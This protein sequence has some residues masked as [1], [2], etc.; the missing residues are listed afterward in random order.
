MGGGGDAI[1]NLFSET[2]IGSAAVLSFS[3]PLS[4]EAIEEEEDKPVDGFVILVTALGL[5][6]LLILLISSTTWT[7]GT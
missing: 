6:L 5:S 2:G 7:G 3:L 4:G 1:G